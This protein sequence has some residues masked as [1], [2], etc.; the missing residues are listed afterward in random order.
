MHPLSGLD[1]K[2]RP[3]PIRTYNPRR[4]TLQEVLQLPSG[5]SARQL[6]S[7]LDEGGAAA[8]TKGVWKKSA[9]GLELNYVWHVRERWIP[10]TDYADVKEATD[11]IKDYDK[12]ALVI[13][14]GGS[15]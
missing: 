14:K 11:A 1:S 7:Q 9:V 10:V 13:E 8:W 5:M 6:P 2:E 4:V 15:K 12:I 3:H